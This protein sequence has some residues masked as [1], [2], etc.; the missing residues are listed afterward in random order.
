MSTT[1]T[2]RASASR[3]GL[4]AVLA[5]TLALAGSAVAATQA[6]AAT[7]LTSTVTIDSGANVGSSVVGSWFRFLDPTG[8]T[9]VPNSESLLT[10]NTY[11]QLVNGSVGLDLSAAQS[12]AGDILTP[13]D[14]FFP[15]GA[16]DGQTSAAPAIYGLNGTGTADPITNS[17]GTLGK[18]SIPLTVTWAGNPGHTYVVGSGDVSGT[19]DWVNNRVSLS[20]H[21]VINDPGDAFDGYDAN[22]HFEGSF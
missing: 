13:Q 6:S 20:W 8:T 7:Q 2:R 4:A 12:G 17:A 18:G 10:P 19:I 5:A 1:H 21:H 16:F 22:W 15:G 11:T 9:W 14:F 3:L